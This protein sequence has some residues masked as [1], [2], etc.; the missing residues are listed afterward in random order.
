[1]PVR[2]IILFV[3]L[4][5]GLSACNETETSQLDHAGYLDKNASAEGVTTTASGLQY[6]VIQSG[7]GRSPSLNSIVKVHYEGTLIDGTKFDSSYDRNEPAQFPVGGVIA[8]WTEALQLMKEGDIWEL[9]IPSEL[10]YGAAGVGG[11]PIEPGATLK[12]KVELIEVF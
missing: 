9:T 8:G 6:K 12:F 3:A 5:L 4:A 11:T 10:G 2:L 1:M 7:E